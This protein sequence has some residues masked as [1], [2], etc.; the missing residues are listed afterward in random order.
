MLTYRI[1]MNNISTERIPPEVRFSRER[2]SEDNFSTWRSSMEAYLTLVTGG[3]NDP[4]RRVE[5]AHAVLK[6]ASVDKTYLE[7]VAWSPL[8]L[9]VVFLGA[10]LGG[11]ERRIVL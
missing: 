11:G 10:I 9:V 6:L 8:S 5:V 2:H 7:V 4:V 3:I 1:A